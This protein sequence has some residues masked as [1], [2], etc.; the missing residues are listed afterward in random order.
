MPTVYGFTD[1][2]TLLA[3]KIGVI[4]DYLNTIIINDSA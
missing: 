2:F 1:W 4:L 3:P